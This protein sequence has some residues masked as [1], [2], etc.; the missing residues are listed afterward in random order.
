M[1]WS[2]RKA[3][4]TSPVAIDYSV[5]V[6]IAICIPSLKAYS[7][8]VVSAKLAYSLQQSWNFSKISFCSSVIVW[9][10]LS[11]CRAIYSI[12]CF[13]SGELLRLSVWG[14]MFTCQRSWIMDIIDRPPPV[15][16]SPWRLLWCCSSQQSTQVRCGTSDLRLCHVLVR[17][18]ELCHRVTHGLEYQWRVGIRLIVLRWAGWC[19]FLDG[20]SS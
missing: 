10:R 19:T 16:R 20:V 15:R 13:I 3:A 12:N 6:S 1:S 8:I 14:H 18:E 4:R 5:N 11:W 2:I 9:S 17:G 7:K